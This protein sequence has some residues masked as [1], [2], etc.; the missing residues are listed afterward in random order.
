[1]TNYLKYEVLV[2]FGVLLI[3]GT[4]LKLIFSINIDSDWFW[5]LAGVAIT[6]EGAI[7]FQNKNNST[8]NIKL[9]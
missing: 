7:N 2:L 8:R 3:V 9:F 5:L 1:M 6:I 4:L